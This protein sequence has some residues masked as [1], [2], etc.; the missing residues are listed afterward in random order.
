MRRFGIPFLIFSLTFAPTAW[1]QHRIIT[2]DVPGAGTT[3][4]Q[5][6]FAWN[7]VNEIGYR[8]TTWTRAACIAGSY[9][10]PM[11]PSLNS[12]PRAWAQALAK[13]LSKSSA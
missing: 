12:T 3:A 11:E 10:L 7:I 8:G 5:G 13:A 2:F 6:T 9:A 4:G 1:A